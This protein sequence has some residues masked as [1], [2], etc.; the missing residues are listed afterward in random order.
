MYYGAFINKSI[1]GRN[2]HDQLW[3]F[4]FSF[5][6]RL[7]LCVLKLVMEYCGAGSITDLVK[8]TK[9]NCLKEEWISFI[10]KEILNGLNHLHLNKIIHRDIKGQVRFPLL[11]FFDLLFFS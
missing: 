4:T 11:S 10:S 1:P 3:V 2:E 6:I 7:F 5:L 9:G 8:S